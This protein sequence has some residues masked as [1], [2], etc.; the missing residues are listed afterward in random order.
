M[1]NQEAAAIFRWILKTFPKKFRARFASEMEWV[2]RK[3]LAGNPYTIRQQV[4]IH[5]SLA[6]VA[7]ISL[8][9]NF[10]VLLG[11]GLLILCFFMLLSTLATYTL[12]VGNGSFLDKAA[13]IAVCL[14][15][16]LLS[17]N[18]C[19]VLIG[20]RN[21]RKFWK[22]MIVATTFSTLIYL[23]SFI[24]VLNQWREW[25]AS[26]TFLDV[27]N[28]LPLGLGPLVFSL[29]IYSYLKWREKEVA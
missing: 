22:S 28:F 10:N 1:S 4:F 9:T 17:I 6:N 18:S 14:F 16:A 13:P 24:Y 12:M 7:W 29:I 21:A 5:C 27:V 8:K 25:G 11:I 26:I 20:S 23:I 19:L 2:F 15:G 3:Q